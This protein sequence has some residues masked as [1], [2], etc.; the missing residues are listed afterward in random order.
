[1]GA[2]S[3]LDWFWCHLRLSVCSGRTLYSSFTEKR[4]AAETNCDRLYL[5]VRIDP[6]SMYWVKFARACVD[7]ISKLLIVCCWLQLFSDT[8]FVEK[9]SIFS[10]PA[11]GY[12]GTISLASSGR[13][14]VVPRLP[15]VQLYESSKVVIYQHPIRS[16]PSTE[17]PDLMWLFGGHYA[18][19]SLS[20]DMLVLNTKSSSKRASSAVSLTAIDPE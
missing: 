19:G 17:S 11:A 7:K 16:G 4:S 1:V 6:Y 15:P 3:A 9:C 13:Y 20:N 5:A 18:D 14:F 8:D 10:G 2:H 12:N